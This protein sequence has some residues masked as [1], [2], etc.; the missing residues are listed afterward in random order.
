MTE[1][2]KNLRAVRIDPDAGDVGGGLAPAPVRENFPVA[3]VLI[4]APLRPS[5][6]AFYDVVRAA[7]DIADHPQLAAAT[8]ARRLNEIE[9]GLAGDPAGDARALTLLQVLSAI[10]QRSAARHALHMLDA[11]RSDIR[12]EPCRDWDDLMRYCHASANPVGRFLLELHG[13]GD[14]ATDASDALCSALQ[15]LNHL[16]DMG[17]DRRELGRVYLPLRM[18]EAAGSGVEDLDR[19]ALTPG[20]RGAFD[21]ALAKTDGLLDR[22]APLPAV[23][24]SRRLAAEA[25]VILSL[26][27]SLRRRLAVGDPLAHRIAPRRRDAA[28]AGAAGLLRLVAM[29][30]G[31]RY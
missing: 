5:V 17:A 30:S 19:A 8:K 26:A 21:C 28:R 1:A 4:A 9:A 7:D 6:R 14:D 24:G 29:P 11:F 15:V 31:N 3:S 23:I 2:T 22:A 12:A 18:I 13:E 27:R 10:G 16:Q 25:R 20:L